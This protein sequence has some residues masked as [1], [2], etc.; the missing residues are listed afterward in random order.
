MHHVGDQVVPDGLAHRPLLGVG[1]DVGR[2]V[3]V[4]VVEG[5]DGGVTLG[6]EL[7]LGEALDVEDEEGW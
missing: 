4:A 1:L 7:V 5:D 3:E 6:D 2:H